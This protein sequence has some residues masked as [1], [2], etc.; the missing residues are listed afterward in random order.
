MRRL[1][2]FAT[3]LIVSM[4]LATGASAQ[5]TGDV[6]SDDTV[7]MVDLLQLL[8]EWGCSGCASDPSSWPTSRAP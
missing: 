5:C 3:A 8:G 6:T 2:V 4:S 7:D 1:I